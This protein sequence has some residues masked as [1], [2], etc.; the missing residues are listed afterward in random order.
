MPFVLSNARAWTNIF[1]RV[2]VSGE[3]ANPTAQSLT[4][5]KIVVNFFDAQNQLVTSASVFT[6]LDVVVAGEKTCFTVVANP[7]AGWTRYAFEPPTY[8]T[9]TDGAPPV[10]LV[11]S[12]GAIS[13]TDDY[14]V[15]GQLQNAATIRVRFAQAIATLYDARGDVVQCGA[16]FVGS[17][18]LEPGQT[19]AFQIDFFSKPSYQDVTTFRVQTD[20]R[21]R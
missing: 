14:R 10:T 19:S 18:D 11:A 1:D 20:G 4:S 5:V 15:V 8:R 6:A 17:T 3:V 13:D 7:P 9:T 16:A 12:R 21:T 2:E